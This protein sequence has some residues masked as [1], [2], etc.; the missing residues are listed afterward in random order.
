MRDHGGVFAVDL[1][2]RRSVEVELQQVVAFLVDG[3]RAAGFHIHLY[4][5]AVV[6][7][8]ERAF[9]VVH[10]QH[11][12]GFFKRADDVQRRLFF[13]GAADGEVVAPVLRAVVAFITPVDC[14]RFVVFFAVCVLGRVFFLG[15]FFAIL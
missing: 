8:L 9:L 11:V 5:V 13:A 1:F 14:M 4:G 12:L 7:H 15:G 10:A 3:Q 2:F 6:E